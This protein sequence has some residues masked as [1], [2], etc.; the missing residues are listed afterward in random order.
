MADSSSS[1]STIAR[2]NRFMDSLGEPR[3]A[4]EAEGTIAE[5]ER[6]KEEMGSRGF[7]TP[8]ASLAGA[9][10]NE[11]LDENEIREL[12]K[13]VRKM[14]ALANAK[15][16][17]LNR[18]IVA[19]AANRIAQRLMARNRLEVLS[20]LPLNGNYIAQLVRHGEHAVTAYSR[21]LNDLSAS[22]TELEKSII[23]KVER[24]VGGKKVVETIKLMSDQKI[25]A[26]VKRAYGEDAKVLSTEVRTEG[27]MLVRSKSVRAC[28][29]SA[30]AVRASS[31]AAGKF[32]EELKAD[33]EMRRYLEVLSSHGFSD[34][35]ALENDDD[36]YFAIMEELAKAGLASKAKEGYLLK[37][38]L[39]ERVEVR[40]RHLRH[41]TSKLASTLMA[42]DLFRY[43]LSTPGRKREGEPLFPGL[44]ASL[45]LKQ[46]RMFA[47]L[48]RELGV[49]DAGSLMLEKLD[50]ERLSAGIKGDL[51]G[52]ALFSLRSKKPLAWC[53]EFF[54]VGEEELKEARE[55]VNALLGGTE[56]SKK[57][58]EL[59]KDARNKR[60]Q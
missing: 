28:I 1:E 33:A 29:A 32:G 7:G 2:A 43:Y 58:M 23:V 49:K 54:G 53:A 44:S 35:S 24:P 4:A 9:A 21:L 6:I 17:T 37:E 41:E 5:L 15:R 45:S 47:P 56:R 52:A 8:F 18:V 40:R 51:F 10:R 12:K 59:V 34:L 3:T 48:S 16:F 30:Y 57:F 55:K 13:Q 38:G 26:R 36:K 46:V 60:K 20:A 31:D 22:A 19:L 27:E 14:K 42:L 50:A 39:A 11:D 25:E